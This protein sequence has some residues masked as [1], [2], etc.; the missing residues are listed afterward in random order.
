MDLDLDANFLDETLDAIKAEELARADLAQ[1][2]YRS[3]LNNL[4]SREIP[5]ERS[6]FIVWGWE[7]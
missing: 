5:L 1:A 6:I 2:N 3:Y 7:L 4:K